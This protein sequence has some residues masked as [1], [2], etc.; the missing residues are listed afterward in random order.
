MTGRTV[1]YTLFPLST[2]ELKSI[3]DWLE[4]DATLEILLRFGSYPEING[5]DEENAEKRLS[6]IASSFTVW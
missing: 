5:L 1:T 4:V 6:E 2:I 3:K